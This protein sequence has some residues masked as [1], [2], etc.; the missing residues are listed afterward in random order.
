[1]DEDKFWNTTPRKLDALLKVHIKVNGG[2][3]NGPKGEKVQYVD[4]VLPLF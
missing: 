3:E 2:E 1:M 4:E